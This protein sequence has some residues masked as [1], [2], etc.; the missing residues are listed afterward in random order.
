MMQWE[1]MTLLVRLSKQKVPEVQH[2]NNKEAKALEPGGFLKEAVYLDLPSYLVQAGREGWEMAG[3]SPAT[4][5]IP[6]SGTGDGRN[7]ILI[8][9][10]RPIGG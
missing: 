2:V 1:Y 9:F 3:M 7:L 10:K 5:H 4:N 6:N 8:V